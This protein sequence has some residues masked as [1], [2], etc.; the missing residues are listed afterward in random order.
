MI[1]SSFKKKIDGR[2]L[3]PEGKRVQVL[4]L[5]GSGESIVEIEGKYVAHEPCWANLLLVIGLLWC[6][7]DSKSESTI[8]F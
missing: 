7:W 5:E 3:H 6:D 8:S 4:Q 1:S 2:V